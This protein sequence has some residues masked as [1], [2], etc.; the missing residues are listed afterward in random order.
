MKERFLSKERIGELLGRLSERFETFVPVQVG[1]VS[2]WRPFDGR[3][4]ALGRQATESPK[5]CLYPRSEP[6]LRYGEGGIRE[7]LPEGPPLLLFGLKPCDLMGLEVLD[8]VFRGKDPYWERRRGEATF[9]V[10]LCTQPEG[11]CFCT[12]VGGSP[13]REEGADLVLLPMEGGWMAWARGQRGE[14]I[15]GD[16]AFEPVREEHRE[17]VEALRASVK[18]PEA[19]DLRWVREKF[20][21][22]FEDLEFWRRQTFKCISCGACTFLCPTCYC[23]NITD[24][25]IP[26]GAER[27]RSWDS[28][29]FFHYT[30]EASGHNPRP[31]KAERYR[32][33]IG[34]KFCYHVENYG[35]YDCSGCGRCIKY[36]PVALDIR[37][38][39]LAVK[40][41]TGDGP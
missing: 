28:C 27:I 31:T 1:T 22:S 7:T 24:E 37:E 34:H 29:M 21:R 5:H 13:M 39:V 10:E 14:E 16:P 26:E 18:G 36:C 30:L 4:P 38:V 6:L 11:T 8:G 12:W 33:R 9:V 40:E 2:L 35:V 3:E 25:R 23:F 15:L 19:E 20:Y 17:A 32:N 41:Y